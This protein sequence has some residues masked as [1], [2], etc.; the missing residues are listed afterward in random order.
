MGGTKAG[1]VASKLAVEQIKT[2]FEKERVTLFDADF[3]PKTL[4]IQAIH[5]ANDRILQYLQQH[6][7]TQG[8]GTTI[9]T[10]WILENKVHIAWV[11]DSRCYHYNPGSGLTQLTKDHSLVQQLIDRGEISTDQA[12][13]HPQGHVITKN[14]GNPQQQLEVDYR[15]YPI[16]HHD[17]LLLCSDGLNGLLRDQEIEFQLQRNN[18]PQTTAQQLISSA[19]HAG[20]YDNITVILAAIT[21]N[22]RQSSATPVDASLKKTPNRGN[23]R[24]LTS[25]ATTIIIF[26]IAIGAVVFYLFPPTATDQLKE[27]L[28]KKFNEKYADQPVAMKDSI[29]E[30]DS[31]KQDTPPPKKI[32]GYYL[33]NLQVFSDTLE[34]ADSLKMIAERYPDKNIQLIAGADYFEL[35]I[36]PFET[37]AMAQKFKAENG[38]SAESIIIFQKKN[39]K[40]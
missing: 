6:P 39:K 8:M 29:I 14:L 11:G 2:F 36:L 10:A 21:D 20:G 31:V 18:T 33:I 40:H 38:L 27:N 19:N 35:I 25:L 17:Q 7:E 23:K 9:V 15:S 26:V 34:A 5:Q 28:E 3:S 4:L 32:T 30:P 22:S 16:E 24:N 13:D 1:E 37:K 12:F